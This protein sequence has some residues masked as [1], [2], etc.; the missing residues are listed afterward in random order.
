M[1]TPKKRAFAELYV[2]T[3]NASEAYRRAYDADNAKPGTV[4]KEAHLLLQDEDVI[5]LVMQLQEEARARN[6]VTVDRVIAEL[7][8]IGFGDLRKL[9]NDDGSLKPPSEW[10]DEVASY[11][12]SLELVARPG[13][14]DEAGNKTI[15]YVQKLRTWDKV[16]ALDRLGRHLGMFP[17]RHELTGKD[18]GPIE[19]TVSNFELAKAVAH[20]LENGVKEK[21]S[22]NEQV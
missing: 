17:S 4:W 10:S 6:A 22:D 20:I 16:A 1:L 19:A 18:G 9:Y 14:G 3:L 15:E 11:V 2:E 12:A 21:D 5:A 8:R 7:A 13:S